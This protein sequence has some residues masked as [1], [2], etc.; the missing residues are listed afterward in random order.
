MNL[1]LA[2]QDLLNIGTVIAGAVIYAIRWALNKKAERESPAERMD[3]S[4][5]D[6]LDELRADNA[7]LRLDIAELAR[8]RNDAIAEAA[9]LRAE[10]SVYKTQCETK[11]LI[12]KRCPVICG[13]GDG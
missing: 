11:S 5:A 6:Y 3:N 9:G 8:E 1:N 7:K 2:E 4:K 10:L 13:G 12:L